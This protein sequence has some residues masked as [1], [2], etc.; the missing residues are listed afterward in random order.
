MRLSDRGRV[1]VGKPLNR[2]T[3]GAHAR[4]GASRSIPTRRAG[5]RTHQRNGWHPVVSKSR[6]GV[7][8]ECPD[9]VVAVALKAS[10]HP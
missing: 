5:E 9:Q 2:I 10:Q 6:V 3:R 8:P 7:T 1:A 4:E